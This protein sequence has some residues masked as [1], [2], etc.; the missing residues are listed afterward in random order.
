M[1]VASPHTISANGL[2]DLMRPHLTREEIT[3]IERSALHDILAEIIQAG[4][5]GACS[6]SNGSGIS[7]NS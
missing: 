2:K 7:A 5:E 3:E 1:S 6:Q 4:T